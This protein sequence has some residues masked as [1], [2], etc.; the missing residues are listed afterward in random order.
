MQFKHS[1]NAIKKRDI[2]VRPPN[3]GTPRLCLKHFLDANRNH[4][5]LGVAQAMARHILTY[6]RVSINKRRIVFS[7]NQKRVNRAW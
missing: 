5:L 3:R 1:C 7:Q 2:L 4:E 6:S